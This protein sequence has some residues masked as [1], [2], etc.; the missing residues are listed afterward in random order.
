M[1]ASEVATAAGSSGTR[2]GAGFHAEGILDMTRSRAFFLAAVSIAALTAG[3]AQA[4]TAPAAG[5]VDAVVVTGTRG[6]PR[7]VANS[8][9]PIDV[10]SAAE[11]RQVS[12]NDTLDIL[13]AIVP[14]PS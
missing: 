6:Q 11:L 8:P 4:Q 12:S 13:K 14:S 10:V 5:D 3:A 7:T 2:R 9:V 1:N